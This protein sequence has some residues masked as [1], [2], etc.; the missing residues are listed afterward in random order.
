MTASV[1]D[2]AFSARVAATISAGRVRRGERGFSLLELLVVVL[3]IGLGV[4]IVSFSVGTNR[5]Q[6]L[7]NDA[8]DF[9]NYMAQVEDEAVL[10]HDTWGVQLYRET[11]ADSGGERIAYRYLRLTDQGWKP[12]APQDIPRGGHFGDNVT[13]TLEVEGTEQLLEPLPQADKRDAKKLQPTIW[14]TAGEVT[15]FVLRLR[16]VGDSDGPSVRSDPL[17]RIALDIKN[18]DENK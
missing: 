14:L 8:R 13:A 12:D 10:S 6:A 3:I 5:P 2:N 4:A 18:D 7:R 15:P 16:F 1:P 17:G 11:D 9:A